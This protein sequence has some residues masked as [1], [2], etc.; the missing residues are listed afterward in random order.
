M[1]VRPSALITRQHNNQPEVLL[2]HY[3]YG[4]ADVLAL[5]GGNP[6]RG[7]TL[8]ETVVRELQEELC[9]TVT[10]GDMVMAGEMLLS[11]R[12]D[13]VLHIVFTAHDVQGDPVLNPDETT[14][15]SVEWVP[16]SSLDT[17]NLYPNVGEAIQQWF[18]AKG[19]LGY[20]GRIQQRYFG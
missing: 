8:T 6:D 1:K 12:A 17:L 19:G 11:E 7:E 10:V 16:I 20:I 5:P 15:L 9:V 13:D 4:E 14:A 2:M 3:R 18:E